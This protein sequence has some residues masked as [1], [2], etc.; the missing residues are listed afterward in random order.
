[1]GKIVPASETENVE[2][3]LSRW[4]R[5][6]SDA[7]LGRFGSSLNGF[8]QKD[9]LRELLQAVAIKAPEV[10]ERRLPADVMM[11]RLEHL[12]VESG[13]NDSWLAFAWRKYSN[14]GPTWLV[15]WR[16]GMPLPKPV[17]GEKSAA[18]FELQQNLQQRG[19][20]RGGLD[21]VMGTKTWY[22]LARF[23]RETGL[24]VTGTADA[25][26]QFFLKFL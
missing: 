13:T 1:M 3:V 8:L 2:D 18:V 16:P 26:T 9:L 11:L 6:S 23:Q 25:E 10:L 5:L 12:P 17:P 14:T 21:G 19:V 15:F 20:L 24:T 22:A 7:E 4:P